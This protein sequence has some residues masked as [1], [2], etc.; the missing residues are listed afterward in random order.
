MGACPADIH[1][2]K[3]EGRVARDGECHHLD[4]VL[5]SR[6]RLVLLVRRIS[7]RHPEHKVERKLL[8]CLLGKDQMPI[9]RR[10]KR[11]AKHT[12]THQSV[13]SSSVS[14]I[15]MVS[16]SCTPASCSASEMPSARRM[17][18]KRITASSYSQY[19][20]AAA[21]SMRSPVTR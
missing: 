19:V 20:I 17:R 11:A 7:R 6:D 13:H 18:W 16:P 21:R 2:R 4:A 12:Q 8:A 15:M 14:P 5:D 1:R 10:V 3:L 9:M